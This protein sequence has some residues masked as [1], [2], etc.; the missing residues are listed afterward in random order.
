MR[1]LAGAGKDI[2]EKA[3]L[4]LVRPTLEYG[5]SVW[6]PYRI[7]EVKKV[8]GVQRT[9]AR[10]V[11]GRVK[12]WRCEVNKK[13]IETK[14]WER[15]SEMV[16]ELGWQTLVDRRRIDRISNFYRAINGKQGWAE[17]GMKIKMDDGTRKKRKWH[18]K[19]VIIT[20]ART[21]RGKFSF[22]RRTGNEWNCIDAEIVEG[23][24][25]VKLLRKRLAN[26]VK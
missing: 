19:K 10:R 24:V 5:A 23:D 4:S 13:G 11:L 1:Q 22:M 21:D 18:S 6:D 2:K 9:A 3:Y 25:P 7:G 16:S 26:C 12:R 15:P 14:V 20:G 17:L 8:E